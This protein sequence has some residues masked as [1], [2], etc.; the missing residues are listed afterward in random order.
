M[1]PLDI[2]EV[3]ESSFRFLSHE[4]KDKVRLEL[5]LPDDAVIIG[6][7]HKLVQVFLNLIQNAYDALATKD[8]VDGET[9]PLEIGLRTRP[10][11]SILYMRDNGPGMDRATSDNAF[12]PFFTTKDVGKGVGLGLSIC[13]QIMAEHG[14]RV[15]VTSEVG[16]YCEFTLEFPE[17]SRE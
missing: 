4:W 15:Q 7:R 12:D 3:V 13:Y 5:K 9:P 8:F 10:G 17:L 1:V 11:W 14:G 16:R 2:R 6:N